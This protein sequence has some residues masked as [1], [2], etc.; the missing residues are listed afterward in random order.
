MMDTIKT[1]F[2]LFYLGIHEKDRTFEVVDTVEL[3]TRLLNKTETLDSLRDNVNEY[4]IQ[5]KSEGIK[6]D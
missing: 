5:A 3:L 1:D 4:K 6:V 2:L